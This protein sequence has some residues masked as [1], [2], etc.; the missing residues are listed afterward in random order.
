MLDIE[1][2]AWVAQQIV[3]DSVSERCVCVCLCM[4]LC[5]CVPD[6]CLHKNLKPKFNDF[7][8]YQE[9]KLKTG[10]KRKV[11][12]KNVWKLPTNVAHWNAIRFVIEIFHGL[13]N[14]VNKA[15]VSKHSDLVFSFALPPSKKC[16]SIGRQTKA[17]QKSIWW[18]KIVV[19]KRAT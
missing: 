5:V 7:Y 4:W 19:T 15:K 6:C 3:V 9:W 2:T 17:K 11:D 8:A 1:V 14:V 12:P 13:Q 16:N 10:T 18:Q